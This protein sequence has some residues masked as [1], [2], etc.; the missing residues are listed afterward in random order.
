M[1]H[2][3]TLSEKCI[4]LAN[5]VVDD[6]DEPAAPVPEIPA[7][8]AERRS[9]LRNSRAENSLSQLWKVV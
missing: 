3:V 6:P 4:E 2:K 9:R 8:S 7:C 1:R 5:R